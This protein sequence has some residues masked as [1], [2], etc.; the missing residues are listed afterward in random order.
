[1]HRRSMKVLGIPV[2]LMAAAGSTVG[3]FALTAGPASA[4]STTSCAVLKATA[5][6]ATGAVSGSASRCGDKA[7]TGAG[8]TFTSNITFTTA[9]IAWK[10]A[11]NTSD[12]TG[13]FSVVGTCGK[14][15]SGT[16]ATVSGTVTG[17]NTFVGD[18]FSG[19][20]CAVPNKAG[21]ALSISLVKGTVFA[22]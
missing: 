21:T 20:V 9:S 8:G 6:I 19:T 10:V 15:G 4:T 7:V 3:A 17:G 5:T 22:I 18:T 16:E 1:M 11:G 13:T 12:L 14:G 2:T